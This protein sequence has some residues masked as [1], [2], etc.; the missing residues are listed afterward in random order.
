MKKYIVL[1]IMTAMSFISVN[2]QVNSNQPVSNQ[3]QNENA[4]FDASSNFNVEYLNVDNYEGKGLVFPT[5]DLVNF[6]FKMD[7]VDGYGIFPTFFNGMIVYNRVTG[8]TRTDNTRASITEFDMPA[9]SSTSTDVVPGFYYYYNPEGRNIFDLTADPVAAVKAGKWVPFGGGGSDTDTKYGNGFGLGLGAGSLPMHDFDFFVNMN[10]VGDSL[11]KNKNFVV[12]MGD[13][14]ALFLGDTHLKDSI[15]DLINIYSSKLPNGTASGQV[16]KWNSTT[17]KWEPGTDDNTNTTYTAGE[18]LT[19]SGTEFS[20]NTSVMPQ[21]QWIY[22]PPFMLEWESGVPGKTV[23]L[24]NQYAIGTFGYTTSAGAKTS[25]TPTQVNDFVAAAANFEYM[26][27]YSGASI[28]ITGISA[29][30]V[31]SYNC[32]TTPPTC[33]DFIS[34]I[35]VKK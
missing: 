32:T 11:V 35:L 31:L 17:S 29:S 12:D 13:K 1:S 5:V 27:R 33:A 18:G 19:L 8:T 23:D 24:Y 7:N 28:T 25:T 9:R 30:G 6:E 3:L 20:V 34:V 22:C 21:G 26:V 4:F 15:V 16:L 10:M 14:V 2:G